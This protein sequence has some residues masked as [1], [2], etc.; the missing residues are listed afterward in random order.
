MADHG[1][2]DIRREAAGVELQR[3]GKAYDVLD[4]LR[5]V[6]N[7]HAHAR[8]DIDRAE[9][10]VSLHNG[11]ASVGQVIGVYEV[12]AGHSRA[13]DRYRRC[14]AHLGLMHPAQQRRHDVRLFRTEVVP[15]PERVAGDN[16]DEADA[17]LRSVGSAEPNASELGQGVGLV[18][19]LQRA[20][21]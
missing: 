18:G 13:P 14:I 4:Q 9:S 16:T 11:N 8:A 3:A 2:P 10:P 12:P 21:E 19:R 1:R 5:Q 17:V 6:P 15:R 20:G 7:G